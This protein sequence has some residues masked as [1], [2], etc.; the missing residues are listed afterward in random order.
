M[1]YAHARASRLC[2]ALCACVRVCVRVTRA[3]SLSA[4]LFLYVY[5][6]AVCLYNGACV[7]YVRFCN[8]RLCALFLSLSLSLFMCVFV[9]ADQRNSFRFIRV[10]RYHA[11][12]DFDTQLECLLL[13]CPGLATIMCA[14]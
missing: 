14:N 4:S 13:C 2:V 7:M 11:R 9:Q 12:Q 6:F 8:M 3:R 5:G 10:I 1:A